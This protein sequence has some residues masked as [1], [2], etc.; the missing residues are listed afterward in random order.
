MPVRNT[1]KQYDAPAYYHVYNHG[2]GEELIFIDDQDRYKFLSL[3][4]RHLDASSKSTDESGRP[5]RLYDIELVAYCL[6]G[7][8][9]HLLVFQK[10]DPQAMTQLMRS[11]ATAYTMYFNRRHKRRGHLFE[12]IFK[13]K[14]ITD[15]AQLIH[16]SR[17]IHR[18]PRSYLR[19][20]WSSVAY[21][22]GEAA[23]G[24]LSPNLVNDLSPRQYREFLEDYK[25]SE[26]K[27]NL[28]DSLADLV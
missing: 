11:V 12:G 15:E 28:K 14:Y 21:Y 27:K 1:I 10:S 2:V 4:N 16:M 13:A 5:Y 19:Y 7:N 18:N 3:L 22:L 24:W 17:Y 20:R 8:H 25:H 6:M 23:P 9:F 26:E